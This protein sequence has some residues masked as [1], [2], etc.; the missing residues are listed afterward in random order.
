[1]P[2]L[3]GWNAGEGASP[4]GKLLNQPVSRAEF[5]AWARSAGLDAGKVT[6][7]YPSGDDASEAMHAAGHDAM[8]ESGAG[9]AAARGGRAPL[10][11]Y[12]FE[13]VMPGDT[14]LTYGSYHSSELPYVFGTLHTLT[15]R[16]FGPDDARVSAILQGYW[17]NFIK[18]GDPNGGGAPHWAAFDPASGSAMAL[19]L[20]PHMRPI[21]TPEKAAALRRP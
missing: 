7:A 12:D 1:M 20:E 21:T 13:H 18:T 5:Q 16:R 4:P 19:G 17:V 6:A 10:Y 9:W 11:Y 3:T 2:I 15:A 14:A 8:M